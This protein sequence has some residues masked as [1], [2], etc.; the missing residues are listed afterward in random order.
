MDLCVHVRIISIFAVQKLSQPS[1]MLPMYAVVDA[2]LFKIADSDR[3]SQNLNV[4]LSQ[5]ASSYLSTRPFVLFA[6]I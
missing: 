6:A 5:K 1:A 2:W 4:L 3:Q